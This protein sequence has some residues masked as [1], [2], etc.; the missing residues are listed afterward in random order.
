MQIETP[1]MP[2]GSNFNWIWHYSF[3]EQIIETKNEINISWTNPS[4]FEWSKRMNGF[5][6]KEPCNPILVSLQKDKSCRCIS[7]SIK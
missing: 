7:E 5:D 2:P 3:Q 4:V 6:C 1:V